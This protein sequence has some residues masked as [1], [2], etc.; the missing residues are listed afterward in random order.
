MIQAVE[1]AGWH[2]EYIF[3]SSQ[4]F[5]DFFVTVWA[6]CSWDWIIERLIY[7]LPRNLELLMRICRKILQR[8]PRSRLPRCTSLYRLARSWLATC[9][10][11]WIPLWISNL[12][13]F[14]SIERLTCFC[15]PRGRS[16]C[17]WSA[18]AA[19][20]D[21]ACT[22]Q[23]SA[24]ACSSRTFPT[25]LYFWSA[26]SHLPSCQSFDDELRHLAAHF[27]PRLACSASSWELVAS[28]AAETV[29]I[30]TRP[31]SWSHSSQCRWVWPASCSVPVSHWWHAVASRAEASPLVHSDSGASLNS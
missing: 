9:F 4:L 14:L 18:A 3:D 19:R 30:P 12:S 10:H 16:P 7:Y 27:A 28:A 8:S 21:S 13:G 20:A 23:F 31:S 22:H 6:V 1:A 25:C 11:F 5:E 26:A 2:L 24:P 29:P 17:P 15:F